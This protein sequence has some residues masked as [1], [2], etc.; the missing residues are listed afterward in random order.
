MLRSKLE[1]Y[2]NSMHPIDPAIGATT[3]FCDTFFT[4]VF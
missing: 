2:E 4:V 3:I 1:Q